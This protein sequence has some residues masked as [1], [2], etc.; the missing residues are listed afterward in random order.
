MGCNSN[1]L[2]CWGWRLPPRG[3][4]PHQHDQR[5]KHYAEDAIRHHLALVLKRQLIEET[6]QRLFFHSL[7]SDKT[8]YSDADFEKPVWK[9]FQDWLKSKLR[10][11]P[12]EA[13]QNVKYSLPAAKCRGV[14]FRPAVSLAFTVVGVTNFLTRAIS[15]TLQAS[16]SSLRGSLLLGNGSID[17]F[18]MSPLLVAITWP[19]LREHY[20]NAIRFP[21]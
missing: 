9:Q 17:V 11:F 2:W 15:P 16:N 18:R 12:D 21:N 6:L 1:C 19:I 4:S 3:A 20:G 8:C 10:G 13:K 7:D 5:S 14:D